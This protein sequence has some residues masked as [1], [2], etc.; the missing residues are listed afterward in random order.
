MGI[1]DGGRDVGAVRISLHFGDE[2]LTEPVSPA[3]EHVLRVVERAGYDL[4][5]RLLEPLG[6]HPYDIAAP[7]YERVIYP[8][9]CPIFA[10][11]QRKYNL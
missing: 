2:V 11:L 10:A 7:Q 9:E 1:G 6:L 5:V 3:V 4:A 8:E